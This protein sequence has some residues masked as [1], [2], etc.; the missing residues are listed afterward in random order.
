MEIEVILEFVWSLILL[1][2]LPLQGIALRSALLHFLVVNPAHWRTRMLHMFVFRNR[3]YI[4]HL[5]L[6]LELRQV[7]VINKFGNIYVAEVAG[8]TVGTWTWCLET[9]C[10]T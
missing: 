9:L 1:V 2:S 3:L 5:H 6:R 7:G 4:I 10:P 8:W